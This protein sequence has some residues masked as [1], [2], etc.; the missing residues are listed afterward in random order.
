MTYTRGLMTEYK[1]FKS[2]MLSN[3]H[4]K[5]LDLQDVVVFLNLMELRSAKK[6]AELMNVSQPTVSYCLRRLRECFDDVLFIPT[7]GCMSPSKKAERITQYMRMT[8]ESINQCVDSVENKYSE[9]KVWRVCAPEYFELCLL[10]NILSSIN[11]K[12]SNVSL[13][14]QRLGQDLPLEKLLIGDVDVAIGFGPGYHQ[15]HPNLSWKSVVSDDFCCLTTY[16]EAQTDIHDYMDID[17]FCLSPHV[18]PTPWISEKNMVDGWLDKIGKK[19]TVLARTNSY[20]SCINIIDQIPA[21]LSLPRKLIPLLNIP[22]SISILSPPLGFP[23]FTLDLVWSKGRS[24][25]LDIKEL[26][27]II[28]CDK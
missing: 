6:T 19:R 16:Q 3:N 7:D 20:Q 2:I 14:V 13:E 8:V 9:Q 23:S 17:S 10:P 15:L 24:E 5:Q 22:K 4:L 21:T 28:I 12:Y 11:Q 25:G 27:K 1:R 26:K 18:F